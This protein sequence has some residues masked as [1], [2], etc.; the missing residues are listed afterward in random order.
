MGLII[1]LLI[2]AIV[3]MIIRKLPVIAIGIVFGT[4]ILLSGV[5]ILRNVVHAPIDNYANL[6]KVDYIGDKV[7]MKSDDDI[8]KEKLENQKPDYDS[9]SEE[10]LAKLR[11]NVKAIENGT[12]TTDSSTSTNDSKNDVRKTP[13]KKEIKKSNNENDSLVKQAKGETYKYKYTEIMDAA[14]REKIYKQH[15]NRI[16]DS[17][18]KS[19]LMGMSN[20]VQLEYDLGN[21]IMYNSSDYQQLIIH[22]K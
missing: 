2:I 9:M 22:Y 16:D 4:T 10:E 7:Q 19:K 17:K 21:A 18:F 8:A 11:A 3:I 20:Y 12:S 5:W 6:E 14:S 13:V 15:K 1:A